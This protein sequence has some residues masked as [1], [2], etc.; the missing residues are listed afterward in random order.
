MVLDSMIMAASLSC[1]TGTSLAAAAAT[2]TTVL[3][4]HHLRRRLCQ[5][6]SSWDGLKP[7]LDLVVLLGGN[8][9]A[10]VEKVISP[11]ASL[12]GVCSTVL[13][14]YGNPPGSCISVGEHAATTTAMRHYCHP[15]KST[16]RAYRPSNSIPMLTQ[17]IYLPREVLQD[18]CG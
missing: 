4:F 5:N 3:I 18:R 17:P 11:P 7:P 8:V 16:N 9:E 6:Q 2:T 10:V 12:R 1:M 14:I 15:S 13:S